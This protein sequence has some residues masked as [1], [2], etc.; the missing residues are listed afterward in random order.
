MIEDKL[1]IQVLEQNE[2][3]LTVQIL[4]DQES[5]LFDG[6]FP[7]FPL[8]PGVLQAHLAFKIFE[9]HQAH[10]IS[11]AG[12]RNIK[13]FNPV[14]PGTVLQLQCELFIEKNQFSFQYSQGHKIYSK[15]LAAVSNA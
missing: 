6:H 7:E 15:G 9:K 13:F 2:R 10:K 3:Q 11:F 12:F 4:F 1:K 8:L 5:G 14:F